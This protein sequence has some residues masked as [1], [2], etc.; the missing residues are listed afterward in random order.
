MIWCE[1]ACAIQVSRSTSVSPIQFQNRLTERAV[2][3][4]VTAYVYI[5]SKLRGGPVRAET[6][7]QQ[8]CVAT[9]SWDPFTPDLSIWPVPLLFPP[10][11]S[12]CLR[13]D[14]ISSIYPGKQ[15]SASSAGDSRSCNWPRDSVANCTAVCATL[16]SVIPFLQSPALD[17]ICLVWVVILGVFFLLT[18]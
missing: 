8:S 1:L 2:G 4:K 5:A 13:S 6:L 7:T 18:A 16:Y 9:T 12:T 10:W 17:L 11:L 14:H 3:R 15:G